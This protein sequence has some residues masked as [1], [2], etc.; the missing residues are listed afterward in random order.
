[1]DAS[2]PT[3]LEPVKETHPVVVKSDGSATPASNSASPQSWS[4]W[5][6]RWEYSLAFLLGICAVVVAQS[7]WKLLTPPVAFAITAGSVDLNLADVNSLKQLPGVGPQLA[8]RIVDHRNTHGPFSKVDDLK[9]VHGIGP[10]T[11]ERL[12]YFVMVSQSGEQGGKTSPMQPLR[13]GPKGVPSEPIDLNTATVQQL[14]NLPGIGPS[15]AD[16]I[17]QDREAHGLFG[18]VS[19]LARIRGIKGKTIEKLMPYVVVQKQG[20]TA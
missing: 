3:S 15:L 11:V 20:K 2:A 1:M 10:T 8:A 5:P 9:A 18:S 14:M 19:D 17:V 4:L 13:S 12:R 16:R 7:A 6:R